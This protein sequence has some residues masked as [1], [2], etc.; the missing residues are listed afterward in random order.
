MEVHFTPEQEAKLTQFARS[1]GT[2]AEEL[3]KNAALRLLNRRRYT[4][5][6]LVQQ[7]G[8]APL[9]QEDRAWLDAPPVGR[10]VL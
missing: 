4:A 9:S 5:A 3:V 2:G 7:H 10:E 8:H 6:E 1:A